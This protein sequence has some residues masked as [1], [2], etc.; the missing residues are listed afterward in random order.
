M[1]YALYASGA[2]ITQSYGLDPRLAEPIHHS[3]LPRVMH[4]GLTN[5]ARVFD[6]HFCVPKTLDQYTQYDVLHVNISSSNVGRLW[7]LRRDIDKLPLDE[8]PLLIVN[9][10]YAV[11]L[12]PN[13]D[14]LIIFKD[15]ANADAI[16]HVHPAMMVGHPHE[17]HINHPTNVEQ[18]AKLYGDLK[19]ES[20][21]PEPV[22]F[23]MSHP[24][25]QNIYLITKVL[26][27]P[28][29][30][31]Y[32]KVLVG[33]C[34]KSQPWLD[35]IYDERYYTL[36]FEKCMEFIARSS[37][38][39]DTATTH[40][41]GRLPVECAALGTPCVSHLFNYSGSLLFQYLNCDVYNT[42]QLKGSIGLALA[43]QV[44]KPESLTAKF[45]YANS[46]AKFME[47]V[48]DTRQAQG[49]AILSA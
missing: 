1:R 3:A 11:E 44:G 13:L 41:G 5:W 9:I 38:V 36:E 28:E 42:E 27:E 12:W 14:P 16:F 47:M 7:R 10:D 31:G 26:Q 4:S 37:V 25:D 8:R 18:L 19:T 48:N 6:G 45:N 46:A 49:R 33:I 21:F 29:F 17:Y 39:I 32:Q 35:T 2:W 43:T 15:L 40:S 34:D 20:P 22:I 23:V 24:Y 30:A